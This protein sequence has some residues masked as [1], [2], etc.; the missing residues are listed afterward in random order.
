MPVVL[1]A[2]GRRLGYPLKL[3]N[4][5]ARKG[6]AWHMFCRWEGTDGVRFNIEATSPGLAIEPDNYYRTGV[7]EVSPN[8][9]KHAGLL[10]SLTAREELA[11]FLGTRG[12][13]WMDLKDYPA[14]APCFAWSYGLQPTNKAMKNRLIKTLN[15]WGEMLLK[16][17]PIQFPEI[18]I[19]W[20]LRRLLPE[21]VP[22]ELERHLIVQ[23][24][25]HDLLTSPELTD[26]WWRSLQLGRPVADL[27]TVIEVRGAPN[28]FEF[29]FKFNPTFAVPSRRD[30]MPD[31]FSP[32]FRGQWPIRHN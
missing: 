14:A 11:G 3:V 20:P 31:C 32:Q 28:A 26:R 10:K 2:I 17:K 9:E 23:H 16:L 6:E 15:D 8:D 30:V 24:A 25:R 29:T 4:A 13:C 12:L 18:V 1:A 5:V 22:L 7:Y 19:Y 27:P 21:E